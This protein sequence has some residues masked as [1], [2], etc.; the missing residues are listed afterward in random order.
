MIL[1]IYALFDRKT[2][3]YSNPM[4]L[5]Q[6]GQAL[7]AMRD[8]VN[9]REKTSDLAKHPDDFDIYKLGKY[10]TD[11]GLLETHVPEMLVTCKSLLE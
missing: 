7:R 9:A 11:S 2:I 4:F 3:Q 8:E 6:D 1:Q 10:D 5:I